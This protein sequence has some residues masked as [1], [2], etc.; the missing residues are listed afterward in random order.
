MKL[1]IG[2]MEKFSLYFFLLLIVCIQLIV[3]DTILP[4]VLVGWMETI[5]TI[6]LLGGAYSIEYREFQGRNTKI[7]WSGDF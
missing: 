3:M 6:P 1:K 4:F 7:V 2:K 5:Q